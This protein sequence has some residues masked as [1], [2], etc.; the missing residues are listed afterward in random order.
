M[1]DTADIP[2]DLA[3]ILEA[4]D[5]ALEAVE[6]ALDP[7]LAAPPQSVSA[8]LKEPLDNARLHTMF[9]ATAASLMYSEEGRQ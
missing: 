3:G 9:A 2:P 8:K 5:A 6:G 1:A 4:V 7:F